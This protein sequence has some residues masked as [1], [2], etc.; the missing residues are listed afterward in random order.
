MKDY[1][2][3]PNQSLRRKRQEEGFKGRIPVYKDKTSG[4]KYDQGN[5]S[6]QQEQPMKGRH[7]GT[8][9]KHKKPAC[10]FTT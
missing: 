2:R 6:S 7:D 3:G 9:G 5:S 10:L 1:V 4:G 8:I